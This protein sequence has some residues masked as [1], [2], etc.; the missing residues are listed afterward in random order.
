MATLALAANELIARIEA[1]MGW[2][3]PSAD[4]NT[5]A[6]ARLND[7]YARFLMGRVPHTSPVEIHDWLFLRPYSTI[8]VWP[9][10]TTAAA[11]IGG[12]GDTTMTV[13]AATFYATML[14][15]TIT[16]DTIGTSYTIAG[17]TS[18]KVLTL[19]ADASAD[20]GDTFTITANGLYA[21][22]SEFAGLTEPPVYAYVS[23]ASLE[24]LDQ[25]SLRHIYR[26][27][28]DDADT[29]DPTDFS[30]EPQD[31]ALAATQLWWLRTFPIPDTARTVI[32]PYRIAATALTDSSSIYPAG[33][34]EHTRTILQFAY[35][36]CER[37]QTHKNGPEEAFAQ[38]LML[39]SI[40]MDKALYSNAVHIEQLTDVDT[41]L[42]V[43]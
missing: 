40:A 37:E 1:R 8:T 5:W 28:R 11:T 16:S 31:E 20:D 15:H 9:S 33:A 36:E 30:L 14:G 39:E 32:I 2:T 34:L 19:S 42:R 38:E 13:A 43:V 7:A 12:A 4:Q 35:A 18:A 24:D 25:A 21:L 27:M 23:G 41:G 26:L 6:L 3:S 22:P 29:D 17:Y 10:T